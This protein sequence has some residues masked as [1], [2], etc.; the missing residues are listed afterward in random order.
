[1]RAFIELFQQ[2]ILVISS[3]DFRSIY[4]AGK[5]S[6]PNFALAFPTA[7]RGYVVHSFAWHIVSQLFKLSYCTQYC[8]RISGK[9]I[10]RYGYFFIIC[11]LVMARCMQCI[12]MLN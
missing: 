7:L 6:M 8:L 10:V 2:I 4:A 9:M 1:M 12:G 3:S 5:Q 11:S